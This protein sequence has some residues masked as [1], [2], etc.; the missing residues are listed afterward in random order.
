MLGQSLLVAGDRDR[1]GLPFTVHFLIIVLDAGVKTGN[2]YLSIALSSFP[3]KRP[4][5]LLKLRELQ[6][7]FSES[8]AKEPPGRST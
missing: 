6:G 3:W 4:L 2:L 7:F 8:T 5:F 1:P